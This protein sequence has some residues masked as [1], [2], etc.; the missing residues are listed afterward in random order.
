[1]QKQTA[2]GATWIDNDPI[3]EYMNHTTHVDTVG[4]GTY[5]YRVRAGQ[6]GGV[7]MYTAWTTATVGG[8]AGPTIPAAPS[9]LQ[10]SDAGS[11][12]AMVSWTDNSNNETSFTLERNPAFT[13]TTSVNANVTSF[14]DTT[15]NGTFAYRVSSTNGAGSS[16]PTG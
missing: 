2:S 12:R 4:N 14:L 11:G 15:G 1:M 8:A 5:R 3:I 7:S 6:W 16:S 13:T 9:G 10:V